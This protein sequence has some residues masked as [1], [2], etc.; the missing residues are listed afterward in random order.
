MG[1][2][3][4]FIEFKRDKQP[5]RPVAERMRDWRQVMLP[6]SD[7]TL[8]KQ[9]ARC[10][11]CGIPFCHQGCPLGNLIPDWNDLVYRDRWQ[12]AYH[13]LHATNN[14]PEL[15][16]RL[17]PAPCEGSCVL[18]LND[19]AVTIKAAEAAIIER[20]F[21]EGWVV[22]QP[23]ARRTGKRV[24]I[25]GS[26]PSGLAAADQLNMAGHSVTVYERADRPGGLLR[27]GIPEFKLEKRWLDRRLGLMQEEGVVF[28]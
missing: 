2:V 4:G 13:R 28:R 27:Y 22:A 16:G 6:W 26:G 14:F 1:K 21:D 19:A 18:G 17:C 12:A 9:G 15:T 11:D 10:M 24:A 23:P 3:T 8:R 25:V 7:E 20:A 5:Y